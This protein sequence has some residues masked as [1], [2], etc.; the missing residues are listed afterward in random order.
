MGQIRTPS[1]CFH[2]EY[3]RINT[4]KMVLLQC[5]FFPNYRGTERTTFKQNPD[6]KEIFSY[7]KWRNKYNLEPSRV[8]FLNCAKKY[9]FGGMNIRYGLYI[10]KV[11]SE[12]LKYLQQHIFSV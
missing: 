3:D 8:V 9:R 7:Y 11:S 10:P 6:N 5:D 12:R 2:F 1:D 4:I